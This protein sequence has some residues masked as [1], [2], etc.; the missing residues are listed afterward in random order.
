[1]TIKKSDS[2]VGTPSPKIVV[3]GSCIADFCISVPRLPSV[4]ETV[5]GDSLS[6]NLGGKGAN[7]ATGLARLGAK[8]T[9]VTSIGD[10]DFGRRFQ[11][12]FREEGIN[13]KYINIDTQMATGL[14]V[15]LV[16]DG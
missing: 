12:L 9:L 6:V 15:P 3:V 4:G 16:L 7:Q 13:G 10:D 5:I 8:V 14:G 1:M 11:E 2:G